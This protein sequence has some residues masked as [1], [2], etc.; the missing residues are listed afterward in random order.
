MPVRFSLHESDGRLP[1]SW[2][3]FLSPPPRRQL[4]SHHAINIPPALPS[5]PGPSARVA[6]PHLAVALS[7]IH[8]C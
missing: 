3:Q 1:G 4:Q 2:G 8:H 5:E 7:A 6:T